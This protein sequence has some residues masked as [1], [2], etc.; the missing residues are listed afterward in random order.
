MTVGVPPTEDSGRLRAE[1]REVVRNLF[2]VEATA[3]TGNL[4]T[5][6]SH[7]WR[8]W[9][10]CGRF[11]GPDIVWPRP[12]SQIKQ[13]FIDNQDSIRESSMCPLSAKSWIRSGLALVALM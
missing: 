2:G 4:S 9:L 8:S 11:K 3:A 5:G 10:D 7:R 6:R 1:S 13:L 12:S